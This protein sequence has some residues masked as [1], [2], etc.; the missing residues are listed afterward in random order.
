[1]GA[2]LDGAA[3]AAYQRR[4]DALSERL[5]AAGR[6]GDP[7]ATEQIEAERRVLLAELRRASAWAAG[8]AWSPPRPNGPGST[9][10]ARCAP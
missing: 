9:S 4:L 5:D 1:M 3:R 7:V 10:P 8:T 2:V 6:A